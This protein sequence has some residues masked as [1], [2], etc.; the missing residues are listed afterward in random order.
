MTLYFTQMRL[1]RTPSARALASL[2]SPADQ[3]MRIDAHH[4]LIWAAF[5]D[6]AD[7]RRDFL[8]REEADGSFLTLSARPPKQMD[9]FDLFQSK[10]FTPSLSAGDTLSFALRV[11]A[12]R[13]KRGAGRVDVVMDALH[14]IPSDARAAA[15]PQIVQSEAVTWLDRQGLKAGFTLRSLTGADYTT[16]TLPDYRGPRK[17]QPQF[18][19]L[20]LTGSLTVTDPK[21]FVEQVGRGFGRAKAFGCGLMLIRRSR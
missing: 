10:P 21:A 15:K 17:G 6:E 20:D 5:A 11:N 8:W 14:A 1:S 19:V 18:G 13:A 12:T 7:R 2:I 3:A 16:L 9:L 4:K